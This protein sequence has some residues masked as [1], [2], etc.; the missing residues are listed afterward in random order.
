MMAKENHFFIDS[1]KLSA[2]ALEKK[3]R[4]ENDPSC[5]KDPGC[6]RSRD[7]CDACV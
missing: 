2:K 7:G 5:R 4:L 3:H 1:D 6:A